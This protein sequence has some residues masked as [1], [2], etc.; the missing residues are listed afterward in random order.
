MRKKILRLLSLALAALLAA[1]VAV[2]NTASAAASESDQIKQQIKQVYRKAKTYKGVDSFDGLCGTLT[3]L[4]LYFMGITSR[5]ELYNGKDGYDAYCR[6]EYTG[7]GYR[8]RAYSAKNGSLLE[9]LNGITNNGTVDAYNLL[10]GFN[11]TPSALGRLYGHSCVIHAILDGQVYFVESYE[12]Y[13]G[14]KRYQEGTPLS[15]SI[16]EFCAYYERTTSEFEGVIHFGLK[17]YGEQCRVCPS[18]FYAAA[19]DAAELRSEPC[20]SE[21]DISS[22][23]LRT[24]TPGEQIRVTGLYLNTEEEYWY[25]VDG[26]QTGYVRAEQVQVRQFLYKDVSVTDVTAPETL[27]QG[28]SFHVQ[29]SVLAQYNEIYTVRA[30][31]YSRDGDEM[32]QVIGATE[33]VEGTEY[34]LSGSD[35]SRDLT[36]RKLAP[37]DYRY[38]L[39]AVVGSYYVTDGQLSVEWNTVQLWASDFQVTEEKTD[40]NTVQ[41]DAC[42]GTASVDQTAVTAGECVGELPEAQRT[43]YVFKGWFTE[44]EGGQRVTADDVPEEDVTLYAQWS[45]VKELQENWI[46]A[47]QCWYFYSDGSYSIGCMEVD[48]TLYYF[49]SADTLGQNWTIWAA[50]EVTP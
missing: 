38:V 28:R 22:E 39:A 30:Q 23:L 4:Q 45:D 32:E 26:E 17:T 48:G 25:Q 19:L 42:G 34:R 14:G 3:G 27:R 1:A 46:N 35:I 29:G 40:S 10:V 47:G 18:S 44:K 49:S 31:V 8:V 37:G 41:F 15:C 33:V 13:L 36:F 12:A 21:V 9:I 7:G 5:I 2:P 16:E 43:G 50:T 6:Q 20:S 11:S 24:L